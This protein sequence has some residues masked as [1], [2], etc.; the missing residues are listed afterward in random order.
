MHETMDFCGNA[1][2][3]HQAGNEAKKLIEN[4]RA[5]VAKSINAKDKDIIIFTSGA[6]EANNM[7]LKGSGCERILISAI[8]HSSITNTVPD[9]EIIPVLENGVID[10]EILERMLKD[11]NRPTLISVMMVNNE[12]GVIQPIKEIMQM[13]KS[14]GAL[15]HTDAV[16]AIGR[17]EL[18][19]QDLGVDFMT[20]TAHKIGGP[21]GTGCLVVSNCNT[22]APLITGGHQE[23]NLRAGTQN[24]IGI[25]GFGEAAKLAKTDM[26]KY[27]ELKKLRDKIEIEIKKIAPEAKFFGS[28]A[29]RVS[30]VTMIATPDISGETQLV[31]LDVEN[32]CVSNGSACTSGTVKKS[33]ILEAMGASD[34]EATSAIRVSLGWNSTEKDVE[35]FLEKWTETYNRIKSRV[36]K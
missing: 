20:L 9:A 6:T 15:V 2:S 33:R 14:L 8:E 31:A 24:L 3:V 32:I 7:V 4:A 28:N 22:I 25:V 19:L 5:E 23:K 29:D 12:T 21:Q 26:H 11:N 35:Y 36:K 1:S 27:Q 13:A 17:I 34:N 16:Q 10:L 30:N 18:D